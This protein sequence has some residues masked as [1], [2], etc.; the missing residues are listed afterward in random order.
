MVDGVISRQAFCPSSS[1]KRVITAYEGNSMLIACQEL[2]VTQG[3][4]QLY[5]IIGLQ[6]MGLRQMRCGFQ[7]ACGQR[8]DHIT[9]GELAV[10]TAIFTLRFGPCD[11][12]NALDNRQ[13]CGDLNACDLR[14][15]DVVTGLRTLCIPR[16]NELTD[17]GTTWLRDVLRDHGAGIKEVD[18][19]S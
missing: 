12:A 11:P 7:V 17:P 8:D 3:D 4:S 13:P 5:S 19:H 10:E 2:A 18:G 1:E 15:K 14:D 9:M 6:G 16:L